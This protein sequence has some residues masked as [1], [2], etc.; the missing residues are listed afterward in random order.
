MRSSE[1]LPP[2]A[3]LRAFEAAGR[4]MSFRKAGEELLITQSSVSHHIAALET[5][6]GTRLFLRKARGVALTAKGERYHESVSRAFA[7]ITQGAIEV[8]TQDCLRVSMLPSFAANWLVPRLAGF[9]E[10]HPDCH[11]E[12][13]PTLRLAD[14]DTEADIAIRYGNGRWPGCET[15][16]LMTE[17]LAPVASPGLL[18][19]SRSIRAPADVLAHPLLFVSRPYEWEIWAKSNGVQL[20]SAKIIQLQDYNVAQQAAIESNG[21]L[22]GRMR[23]SAGKLSEGALVSLGLEPVSSP[24]ASYWIVTRKQQSLSPAAHKFVTW[25]LQQAERTTEQNGGGLLAGRSELK[26][27]S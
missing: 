25:L 8:R 9:W 26:T 15:R 2:L 17:I 16:R 19:R 22:M 7:I 21:I 5:S 23:L 27:A 18:G 1:K 24:K 14:L 20:N 3:A 6:L 4:L 12:I 13:D 11:I 10:S